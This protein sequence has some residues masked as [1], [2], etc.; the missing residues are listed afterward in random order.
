M[1]VINSSS[2]MISMDFWYMVLSAR[3]D[4]SDLLWF[5]RFYGMWQ[6]TMYEWKIVHRENSF[7]Q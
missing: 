7:S 6:G 5:K 1:A 4:I 2:A 3:V